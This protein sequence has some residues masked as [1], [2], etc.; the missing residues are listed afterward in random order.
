MKDS[1]EIRD[2]GCEFCNGSETENGRIKQ[3][4]DDKDGMIACIH[5]SKT[6]KYG[7]KSLAWWMTVNFRGEQRDFH[8]EFCP[9]CGKRLVPFRENAF[10][11][12]AC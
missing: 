8:I 9:F 10:I 3:S 6:N 5:P 7:H 2:R 1:V 4:Y 12:D 11:G